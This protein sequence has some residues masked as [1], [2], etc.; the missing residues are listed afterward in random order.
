MRP[1]PSEERGFDVVDSCGMPALPD[2]LL[3]ASATPGGNHVDVHIPL[4]DLQHGTS[5]LHRLA[6]CT[7]PRAETCDDKKP[8]RA[9]CPWQ[10][11]G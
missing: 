10:C 9:N 5:Y 3:C 11:F 8:P 6:H 2:G 7:A 4:R 1:L